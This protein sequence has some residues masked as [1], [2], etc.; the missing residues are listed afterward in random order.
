[1]LDKSAPKIG[2]SVVAQPRVSVIVP[3]YN[4]ASLIAETL[5][6]VLRQTYKNYEII[7]V[8]DGSLDTEELE[9]ALDPYLDF[10]IYIEQENAGCAAARNA[11][12]GL[13]GGELLAFLDG[14]DIWLPAYLESQIERL[15]RDD[16][17]MIYCDALIFGEPLFENQTF[18]QSAPSNGAVTPVSLIKSECNVINSGTIIRRNLIDKFGAFDVK[19]KRAQDFDMWFRLAKGKVR[20]GYQPEVL[21]KYRVRPDNLS[22]GNVARA[23]RN[24]SILEI[25]GEKYALDEAEREALDNQLELCEAE[26]ELERGKFCLV[27]GDYPA[28]R[29]HIQTANR[30]YRKPKLFALNFMLKLAPQLTARLFKTFRPAEFSFIAPK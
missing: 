7:L 4:V 29:R 11:A 14:D 21:L 16:L 13:A 6:S 5:D 3:V 15:D 19:V 1:M 10:L 12:I 25:V 30:F 28:A 18:T 26:L 23:E 20:I 27:R 2:K 8:N 17:E 24:I 9:R 22:G